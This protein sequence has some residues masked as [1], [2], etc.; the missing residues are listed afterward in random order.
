MKSRRAMTALWAA[1]LL[2]LAQAPVRAEGVCIAAG[3]FLETMDA[4][5]QDLQAAPMAA[6]QA[7]ALAAYLRRF[8]LRIVGEMVIVGTYRHDG[9][10]RVG[11]AVFDMGCL[12]YAESMSPEQW[13][14]ARAAIFGPDI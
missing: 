4:K 14:Q 8:G 5:F 11:L 10:P 3:T 6:A 7:K 2:C 1:I 9:Q 13:Q 12:V